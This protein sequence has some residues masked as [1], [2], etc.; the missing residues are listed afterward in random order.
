M[1]NLQ[2]V[3]RIYSTVQARAEGESRGTTQ[4]C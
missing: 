2:H 3:Y 1:H 4:S